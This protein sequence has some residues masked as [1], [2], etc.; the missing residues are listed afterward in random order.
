VN[1]DWEAAYAAAPLLPSPT[2]RWRGTV[3]GR[4]ENAGARAL[5]PRIAQWLGFEA[6]AWGIDFDRGLWTFGLPGSRDPRLALGRFEA[7][8]ERSRWRDTDAIGLHYE[9]SRLPAP[10][11]DVLY[12]EVKP[13]PDGTCLGIGGENAGPG[14]GDHFWYRLERVLPP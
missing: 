14:V 5:R 12:D 11:R 3:L 7:R 10:I 4:I 9:V 8:R 1:A 2:G 13:M 6:L